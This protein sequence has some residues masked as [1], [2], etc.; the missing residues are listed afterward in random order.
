MG[1]EDR[2]MIAWALSRRTNERTKETTRG[3]ETGEDSPLFSIWV[4]RARFFGA[5]LPS[6]IRPA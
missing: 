6:L 3:V 1:L 4:G 5:A 2:Q